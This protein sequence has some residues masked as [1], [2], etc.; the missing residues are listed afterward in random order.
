MSTHRYEAKESM[1]KKELEKLAH[2]AAA[3]FSLLFVRLVHSLGDVK[4]S[5]A[6]VLVQVFPGIQDT[7]AARTLACSLARCTHTHTRTHTHT[8][9]R[10]HAR[11]RTRTHTH[12]HARTHAL[13]PPPAQRQLERVHS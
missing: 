6:S 3:K 9:A 13:V 10:T 5:A 7:P 4:I 1:A 8:H 11:T 12:K 2:E